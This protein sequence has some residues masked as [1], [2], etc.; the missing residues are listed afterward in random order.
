MSSTKVAVVASTESSDSSI[1]TTKLNSEEDYSN[2][3]EVEVDTSSD[4]EILQNKKEKV[5]LEEQFGRN[6]TNLFQDAVTTE[7]IF[8]NG[9]V[10]AIFAGLLIVL[11]A[12]CY[13]GLVF[14]RNKL[15]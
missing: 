3:S 2:E 11:S 6:N 5:D 1:S 7:P 10:A 14:W 13:L 4:V 15:E 9:H 8:H 12:L